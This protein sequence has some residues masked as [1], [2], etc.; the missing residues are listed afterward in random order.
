MAAETALRTGDCRKAAESY[1]GAAQ[2]S[3]EMRVV[4]RAT[5][6]AVGCEQFDTAKAAASRWRTLAPY[7]GEAALA[8]ALVALKLYDLTEARKHLANWRDSGSSA[9][10]DPLRFAELLEEQA[11]SSVVHQVFTDTLVGEDPTADVRLAQA[12]L[13]FGASNMRAA[14]DAARQARELRTDLAE[15]AV[16]E[17]RALAVLGEHDNALSVARATKDILADEEAFLVADLLAAA[18]RHD[19]AR[20]ELDRL[21]ANADYKASADRRRVAL[22]MEEGQFEAAEAM[23]APM[24]RDQRASVLLVF[25]MAELVERR[26][27]TARALQTYQALADSPLGLQA[28]SSAAKLLMKQGNTR[29]ALAALNEHAAQNREDVVEVATTR[30]TLL[31]QHGQVDEALKDLDQMLAQF[32]DHPDLLYQRSAVLEMGDRSR[33][34]IAELEKLYKQRPADPTIAN[35]LGFTLA[36]NDQQLRK[37]EQLIREALKVSP[38]SAAIQDSLGWV[39]YRQGKLRDSVPILER[40]WANNRDGEIAAHLGEALWK[41]GQEGKARY[42]WQQALNLDTDHPVLRKTYERLTGEKLPAR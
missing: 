1:L 21:A 23:L 14:I 9:S 29:A 26:G 16:I 39:L 28:R 36:D 20:Q 24:L 11:G 6:L 35:A 15:A 18:E 13:A 3:Q 25:Y 41:S 2:A 17:A 37:A 22:L 19:E 4:Q 12:R 40:A 42:L 10:Q 27:D 31:A 33:E 7:S 8:S 34:S 30:S 32:P 5:E 38:D